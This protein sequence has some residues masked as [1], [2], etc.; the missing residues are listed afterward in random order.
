MPEYV[1][2]SLARML[3]NNVAGEP[4]LPLYEEPSLDPAQT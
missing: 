1:L 3:L 2:Q 4:K